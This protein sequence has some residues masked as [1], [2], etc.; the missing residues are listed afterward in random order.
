MDGFGGNPLD[1]ENWW[2][3]TDNMII[4]A[5][6]YG[7]WSDILQQITD[8]NMVSYQKKLLKGYVK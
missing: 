7:I 2:K 6:K 1:K 4:R 8:L 3:M 5:E